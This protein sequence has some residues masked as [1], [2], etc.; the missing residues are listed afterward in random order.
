MEALYGLDAVDIMLLGPQRGRST[1]AQTIA[2]IVGS[3]AA[4]VVAPT[5]FATEY[6]ARPSAGLPDGA[7]YRAASGAII[8]NQC[9]KRYSVITEDGQVRMMTF[10]FADVTEPLACA[11]RIMA[12]GHRIGLDDHEAYIEHKPTGRR[13]NLHEEGNVFVMRA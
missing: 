3:A 6:P 13:V 12:K 11:G 1:S 2:T 4:E 8:G 5:S 10:Q 9:E 7:R